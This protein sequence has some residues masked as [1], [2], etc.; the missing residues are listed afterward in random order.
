[1]SVQF[2]INQS[3]LRTHLKCICRIFYLTKQKPLTSIAKRHRYSRLAPHSIQLGLFQRRHMLLSSLPCCSTHTRNQTKS[4]YFNSCYFH[5]M[6]N[7]R[8]ST[9]NTYTMRDGH[10]HSAPHKVIKNLTNFS[11]VLSRCFAL[12]ESQIQMM[13]IAFFVECCHFKFDTKK[14]S[15]HMIQ[16]IRIYLSW[17]Q[18]CLCCSLCCFCC[19]SG[20]RTSGLWICVRW[21]FVVVV[22]EISHTIQ[23]TIHTKQLVS[24][25]PWFG[26]VVPRS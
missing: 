2:N 8:A 13:T 18:V 16:N 15:P 26:C 1:M 6:C 12:F 17:S 9:I 23:Y 25:V 22:V 19:E 3:V 20:R 14:Y 10:A 24:L 7:V 4:Y 11:F 21:F 5:T